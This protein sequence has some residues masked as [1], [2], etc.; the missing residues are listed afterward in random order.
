MSLVILAIF[1]LIFTVLTLMDKFI[2]KYASNSQ[3]AFAE[4]G[5]VAEQA[6]HS[7]RTV[8]AFTLQSRFSERYAKKLEVA[9]NIGIKR[10][11]VNG[12]GF[13]LFMFLLFCSF[14]LSLWY[15]SKLVIDGLMTGPEVFV[16]FMAMLIG[17]ISFLKLPPNLSAVSSARGAAFKL[18][19]IIDRVPEINPDDVNAIAPSSIKGSIEFKNVTFKYPT[20]PDVLILDNL[21]INIEPGKTVAFVGP[22]GSGKSTTVQLVQRF[23]DATAGEVTLDGINVKNLKVEWLRQQIG[24]VSQEPVLFNMTVRQNILMGTQSDVSEKE[25]IEACKEANCHSFITQL[26]QGYDTVVGEHGGMLSGGQKQRVAIAR[27]ILKNPAILLLDEVKLYCTYSLFIVIMLTLISTFFR[28]HLLSI[29]NLNVLSKTLLIELLL[30][31]LLLLLPIVFQ[32]LE[33][34]IKLLFLTE[35][36]L[37]SKAP[38]KSL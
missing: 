12:L 22:S 33:M 32:Q 15:G 30:P 8:Y 20:R 38:T 21:N 17:C 37:L 11:I 2:T 7:I 9:C 27:A 16:V 19:S 6:F 36:E 4:A 24:V 31:V 29:H 3:Q 25:I 23:Y 34:L 14:S 1:P 26:P 28:P 18:F 5:S 10:G 35:E 13:A